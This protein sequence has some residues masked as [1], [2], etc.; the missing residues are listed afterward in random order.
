MDQ[1]SRAGQYVLQVE[2]ASRAGQ[3]VLL[4]FELNCVL[5]RVALH[6]SERRCVMETSTVD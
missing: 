3:Y 2:Q 1:V 5:G 6:V 4:M